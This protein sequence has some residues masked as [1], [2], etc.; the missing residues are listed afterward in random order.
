MFVVDFWDRK[1]ERMRFVLS[2]AILFTEVTEQ[3]E[4]QNCTM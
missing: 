1:Q 3:S 4:M 2:D